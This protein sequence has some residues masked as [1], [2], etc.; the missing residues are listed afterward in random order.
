MTASATR[1]DNE[2]KETINNKRQ[3]VISFQRP[4]YR[5]SQSKRTRAICGQRASPRVLD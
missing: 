1:P 4:R 3:T 2:L 5:F